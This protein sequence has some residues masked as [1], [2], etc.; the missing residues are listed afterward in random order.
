LAEKHKTG[1]M[2][3]RRL[4]QFFD[5]G[6][7]LLT[8]CLLGIGLVALCGA[9]FSAK[10][11]IDPT[12][13]A[14]I[15]KQLIAIGTGMGLMIIL[16]FI[17]YRHLDRYAYVIYFFTLLLL[18][19]VLYHGRIVAGSRRWIV[20]GMLRFQPS[21]IAKLSVIIVL[22]H[23]YSKVITD[24]G[25][26]F[27]D[28]MIP[29]ILTGLPC[30]FVLKQPDLGTSALIFL[31]ASAMTWF[32]K[33]KKRTMLV[34]LAL[35]LICLPMGWYQLKDYQKDRIQSFINP[36][37]DPLGSGYHVIQ[38]KIAIGSGKLFGKGFLKGTQNDL[39]FL[40]EQHTDFIFSVLAEEWGFV[41]S[42]AVIVTYLMLILWILYVANSSKDVFSKTVSVGICA[43]IFWQVVINI[44]MVMGLMPVVGVTLPLISYGGSS[45]VT[46][47][48]GIGIVLNISM[49]RYMYD[50]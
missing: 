23:Y 17:D 5:W 12:K 30:L 43:M 8:I 15:M 11:D 20:L 46:S 41:G 50:V 47:L 6:L 32:V 45:I 9:I 36:S 18:V 1:I 25:L 29:L 34:I 14:L 19:F 10:L 28:L 31:N 33:V 40:P 37:S 48:I 3:D 16:L 2:F 4:I 39:A 24:Q 21:E 13:T 22:G 42:I 49:R 35:L 27:K 7:L 38:S 26:S 44:G